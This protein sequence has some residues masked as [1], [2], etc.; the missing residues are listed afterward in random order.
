MIA[1][2]AKME[3]PTQ[4]H[5]GAQ[6]LDAFAEKNKRL[7]AP[8]NKE[9]AAA[10]VALAKELNEQKSDKITVDEKLLEKLAFTSQGSLVG[11]TAFLGGVVAQEGIKSITGK[12]APLHQWVR[13]SFFFFFLRPPD[14]QPIP[15]VFIH[16]YRHSCTWTCSRCSLAR[17]SMPRSA[18]LRATDTTLRLCAWARTSTPSSSSSESSWYTIKA[19]SRVCGMPWI[20]TVLTHYGGGSGVC[21]DWCWRHRL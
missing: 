16:V 12:F 7:P 2:W 8:W 3:N 9:D 17:T 10:L 15:S 4:L 11:I 1:D 19:T 21:A 18:N 14:R 13:S 6:A 20:S 5:L